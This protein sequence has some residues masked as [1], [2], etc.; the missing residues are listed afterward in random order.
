MMLG[1]T[2]GIVAVPYSFYLGMKARRMP[3]MR[4]TY[5]RRMMLMP[6][7][8]LGIILITGGFAERNFKELSS[9]YFGHLSDTDLD[10]FENYYHMLR[11]GMPMQAM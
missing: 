11:S 7:V 4:S 5:L 6:T 8:P 3:S 10:N 9:K 2:S 1:L